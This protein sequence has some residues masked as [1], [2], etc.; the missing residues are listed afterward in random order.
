MAGAGELPARRLGSRPLK[1][2]DASPSI[3]TIARS[4]VQPNGS[5]SKINPIRTTRTVDVLPM[6]NDEVTR[7]PLA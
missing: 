3:K 6:T 4:F 1:H 2:E 7:Q 5:L